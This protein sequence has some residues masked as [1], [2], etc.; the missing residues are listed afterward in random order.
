[1]LRLRLLH[2]PL[3]HIL[4]GSLHLGNL[5]H[6]P[7]PFHFQVFSFHARLFSFGVRGDSLFELPESGL[8]TLHQFPMLL[9][10]ESIVLHLSQLL[11]RIVNDIAQLVNDVL[12]FP[13]SIIS[14][15]FAL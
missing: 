14:R 15:L 12:G 13:V 9:F 1:M 4:Q 2:I 8:E 10:T 11:V 3:H 5:H 6:I 7:L